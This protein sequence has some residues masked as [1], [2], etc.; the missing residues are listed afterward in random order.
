[1]HLAHR[2]MSLIQKDT[3]LLEWARNNR[4]EEVA[5]IMAE[6]EMRSKVE[7]RGSNDTDGGSKK[8]AGKTVE[9]LGGILL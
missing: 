6:R 8:S 2:D 3:Q 1:M 5:A 7:S 4:T 9:E